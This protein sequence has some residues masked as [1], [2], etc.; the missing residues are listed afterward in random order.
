MKYVSNARL[1]IAGALLFLVG[2][3]ALSSESWPIAGEGLQPDPDVLWG[4]LENG[5]RYAVMPHSEP[6]ERVSLRLHVHAGSLMEEEH[7]RGLAHYL[8]HMAFNGTEN[9]AAEE[10]IKYFQR[11][12]MAFGADTNAYTGFDRTVYQLELPE[13][14]EDLI[15]D[16]LLLLRDYCDRMILAPDKIESERGVIISEKRER[17]TAPFRLFQERLRFVLPD[18]LFHRRMPIGVEETIRAVQREDFVT[19]YEQWY[20]PTRITVVAVG[21]VD[22]DMMSEEIRRHFAGM[23]EPEEPAPAPDLGNVDPS[24]INTRFVVEPEAARTTIAIETVQPYGL[25]PDSLNLRIHQFQRY[26][27]HEIISRRLDIIAEEEDAVISTGSAYG[28]D[29]Q[30][31]VTRAI[32]E[33]SCRPADWRD[34]LQVA[35]Q[36]L[37]RALEYGFTE[38]EVREQTARILRRYEQEAERADT[39]RSRE[40]AERIVRGISE[41]HVYTSPA[42]DLA[43]VRKAL[44][45]MTPE[46]ALQILRNTW[47][48]NDSRYIFIGGNLEEEDDAENLI[49]S[50]YRESRKV[51]VVPPVEEED[52]M[53]AYVD[54]GTPGSISEQQRIEDLGITRLQF[55]NGLRVN[56]KPTDFE[57][58]TIHV[59]AGFGSGLL[60]MP[61]DM[62]GLNLLA[63][64]LFIHGGLQQHSYQEIQR[65]FAGKTVNVTFSVNDNV[66]VLQGSTTSNDFEAQMRLL[67]AY[68]I[69]PGYRE[70]SLRRARRNFEEA[71][72]Q[73]RHDPYGIYAE[74][75]E[76][77]LTGDDPRFGIPPEEQL[78]QLSSDDV[79]QW[80]RGPL[81]DGALELSVVGDF[82]T[83]EVIPV[84]KATLGALPSR[85]AEPI[86][87]E[88]ALHTEFPPSEDAKEFFFESLQPE[89]LVMVFWPT[90]D[91]SDISLTRRL[92]LLAAVMRDRVRTQIREE[93]G[94]SYSPTAFSRSS[95]TFKDYGFMTAHVRTHPDHAAETVR[96][97][98]AIGTDLHEKGVDSDELLRA[99]QPLLAA[100]RQQM[101][102]NAY[103]LRTVLMGSSWRPEKLDWARTI[104]DDFAAIT[105]EELSEIAARY[106]APDKSFT[107]LIRSREDQPDTQ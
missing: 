83:Q 40:I 42:Q 105:E 73:R 96:R 87:D 68:L 7:E 80:L 61:R 1:L 57:S 2:F 86:H 59:A 3:I 97:L 76:R 77:Y 49:K 107:I 82:D 103:W 5:V 33:I 44:E 92:G 90:V 16:G 28:Y 24:G 70:E 58:N 52:A 74:K 30:D 60:E 32:L 48:A 36:E 31:F 95:E 89:V 29:W 84:L 106:L 43:I 12:G 78:L 35:E 101:R 38:V 19:F 66:F 102:S 11:L 18:T 17:N 14:R 15:R 45:N 81:N 55:D 41:P 9:F 71:S 34:A 54:F 21:N 26:A 50:I 88:K 94:E 37:R 104:T 79:R 56:L 99:Q 23:E 22:A 6:P 46:D 67:T 100:L 75:V 47:Q 72:L 93:M 98:R 4:T 8:E 64:A 91:M 10:M 20:R 69:E 53:F 13:G 25:G 65:L 51:D 85:Q 27:A 62:P 39:R 63:E